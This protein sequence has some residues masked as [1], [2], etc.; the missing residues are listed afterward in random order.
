VHALASIA[1]T[2]NGVVN[3]TFA[4]DANGNMTSGAGR[5]A[6]YTSFNMVSN[7]TEG[8][9]N[10]SL[11]YDPEHARIQ[12]TA[13]E[14]ATYYF[15]DPNS[16][17]MTE[18]YF[19]VSGSSVWRS[20]IMAD[21]KIVA[22]RS[23]KSSTVTLRYFVT[24]HL[25]ST[26]ALTKED[27]TL[28]ESDA[29]DPWGKARDATTG[30][31]DTT[32]SKPTQSFSTRG[33]TGHE[34]MPDVCLVNMNARIYDP[35]IGRF[36]SPDDVVSGPYNG[37]NWN[38]YTYVDNNPLSYTDP[39]GH[40]VACTGS[41]FN[42]DWATRN[43]D[44]CTGDCDS[45]QDRATEQYLKTA[46]IAGAVSRRIYDITG[47]TASGISVES[48]GSGI[49][50]V[51]VPGFKFTSADG[52]T[53]GS[54]MFAFADNNQG[55]LLAVQIK[56]NN[57]DFGS[58]TFVMTSSDTHL[59]DD[60]GNPMTLEFRTTKGAPNELSWQGKFY[61]SG[62][63]SKGGA[64]IQELLAVQ[65][66]IHPDGTSSLFQ[67]L[68]KMEAWHVLPGHYLPEATNP[69][70]YDDDLRFQD[71]ASSNKLS[72][73]YYA[74]G[75]FYE[76]MSYPP[77]NFLKFDLQTK[78]GVLPSLGKGQPGWPPQLPEQN[79]SNSLDRMSTHIN[80]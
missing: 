21:G 17:A 8:T 79:G 43:N 59:F 35:S 7:V 2:V 9:T 75:K 58:N 20:Y 4:Y 11:L 56:E 44:S 46:T 23:L 33:Y 34:E 5:T 36:M 63:T 60:N 51:D 50:T 64:I 1:G 37:Q 24:D 28:A 47:K 12:Q 32:C 78:S 49:Y 76:S 26:V 72:T 6:A 25:G 14:G 48:W 27:G 29:Y 67:V 66:V 68:H 55:Q 38:R 41:C 80:Q 22:E 57:A 53:K 10:L 73:T 52:Q 19:P 45:D 71:I 74:R 77:E 40:M 69:F 61:L 70:G 31:D 62:D 30:A 13:P 65:T 39:T 42:Y 54:S 3:P 15:N 16:G 18:R